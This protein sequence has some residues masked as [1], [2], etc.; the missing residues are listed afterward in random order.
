MPSV[1][2]STGKPP[3]GT[4]RRNGNRSRIDLFDATKPNVLGLIRPVGPYT[5]IR[6]TNSFS[7]TSGMSILAPFV[8]F[9][10]TYP[11]KWMTLAGLQAVPGLTGSAVSA[12]NATQGLIIPGL[13]SLIGTSSEIVPAAFSV[14][15]LNGNALQTTSGIVYIGRATSNLSYGGSARTWG[16][17]GTDLSSVSNTVSVAASYLALNPHVAHAIPLDYNECSEFMEITD[18][19]SYSTPFTWATEGLR[20]AAMSPLF[21]YNP[22]GLLLEYQVTIQWRLRLDPQNPMSSDHKTYR[23]SSIKDVEDAVLGVM[24]G[25]AAWQIENAVRNYGTRV[26]VATAMGG[27]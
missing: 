5:M 7:S 19:S 10:G 24:G 8:L 4:A 12:T 23:T 22:S 14:R 13:V 17:L 25:G 2:F 27:V 1:Q 26:A 20:P 3:G 21:V 9:D 11:Q 18:S 16:Q 6:T 15:L